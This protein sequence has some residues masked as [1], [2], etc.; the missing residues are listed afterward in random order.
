VEKFNFFSPFSFWPHSLFLW[1][2]IPVISR[3]SGKER[4]TWVSYKWFSYAAVL[5]RLENAELFT[6][7]LT[8][9]SCL[10]GKFGEIF[11][12]DGKDQGYYPIKIQHK[13][14]VKSR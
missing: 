2:L 7:E 9:G 14:Y 10:L 6:D 11:F 8:D 5:A 4:K 12:G 13:V 1:E 3:G